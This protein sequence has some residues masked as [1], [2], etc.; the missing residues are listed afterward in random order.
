MVVGVK[1]KADCYLMENVRV[2]IQ[3]CHVTLLFLVIISNNFI[4]EIKPIFIGIQ[5]YFQYIIERK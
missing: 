4:Q 3:M 1:R 5:K 2:L